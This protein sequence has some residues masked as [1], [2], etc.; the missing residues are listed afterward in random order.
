MIFKRTGDMRHLRLFGF[1]HRHQRA[2]RIS[3][4]SMLRAPL[5]A[6]CLRLCKRSVSLEA[7]R[8]RLVAVLSFDCSLMAVL[9]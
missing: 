7:A 3:L 4:Y 8:F 6:F 1:S 2:P 9:I 5:A